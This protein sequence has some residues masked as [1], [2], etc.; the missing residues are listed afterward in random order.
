MGLDNPQENDGL[1]SGTAG[2]LLRMMDPRM[3]Q[4]AGTSADPVTETETEPGEPGPPQGEPPPEDGQGDQ[5][6]S[7]GNRIV[8]IQ[9]NA[10]G[11]I[12]VQNSGQADASNAAPPDLRVVDMQRAQAMNS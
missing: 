8:E 5:S 7:I 10:P 2:M 9:A 1:G 6:G 12:P 3:G 11:R 4:A